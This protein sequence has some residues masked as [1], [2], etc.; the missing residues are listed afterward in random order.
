VN[1]V[2][3][4]T[5]SPRLIVLRGN[6]GSGKSTVA[7]QIR[8]R[9][10]DGIALVSQDNLRRVVLG[11]RDVPGGA[12]IGLIDMVA[13]YALERGFHVIIE[14]ILRAGRYG[15]MLEALC[16][17]HRGTS[18]FYYLDV[19]LAETLRRH[20]ARPQAAEF[21]EAEIRRWYRERDLLTGG[22]EQVI[23]PTA[24]VEDIVS[25]VMV[26]AGLSQP[27]SRHFS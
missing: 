10:G 18:L 15:A 23:P 5:E 24:A 6:S 26:D 14:G 3:A 16:G 7:A 20:A 4:G 13:R 12:N 25:K 11:E 17:D 9:Y 8:A 22:V 19:P 1:W 2:S 27:T 21:G